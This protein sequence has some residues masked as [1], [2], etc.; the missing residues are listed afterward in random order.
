[1]KCCR[2]LI[3]RSQ[4]WSNIKQFS[5]SINRNFTTVDEVP[6]KY[7][8]ISVDRSGLL[9]QGKY[10]NDEVDPAVLANKES[11]SPLTKELQFGIKAR[12]PLTI[13]EYMSQCLHHSTLG[14]Y[15]HKSSKIGSEGD[16]ITS[17]EISQLF[18]EMIGIW[19]VSV[20][21]S[22]GKPT[23]LNIIE[24]GPGKGT[25]MKDL[26]SVSE[27]FK[28][29][30]AALS[31]HFVELSQTMR[32]QQYDAVA[33]KGSLPHG[34]PIEDYVDVPGANGVPIHWYSF[35]NQVPTDIGPTIVI[36]KSSLII[37]LLLF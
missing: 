10:D 6:K 36:G 9:G 25:L 24:L 27:R 20:W 28:P 31:V 37:I 33:K 30:K 19:C 32:I 3:R 12:G 23:K 34:K 2:V 16:F 5:L 26:L 29:F 14:Y 11:P 17:P 35:L 22:L 7:N 8:K 21:E 13:H 18:G 4:R 15:Q 1:M